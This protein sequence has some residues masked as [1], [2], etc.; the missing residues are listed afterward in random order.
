MLTFVHVRNITEYFEPS[1]STLA[2]GYDVLDVT[3]PGLNCG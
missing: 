2:E 3:V 1:I